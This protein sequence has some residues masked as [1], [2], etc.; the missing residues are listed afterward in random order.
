MFFHNEM[1]HNL[2]SFFLEVYYMNLRFSINICIIIFTT[3]PPTVSYTITVLT[4]NNDNA[5]TDAKVFIILFGGNDG[6]KSSGKIWLQG[7]GD[8]FGQGQT[9]V[10]NILVTQKLSPLSKIKIGHDNSEENAGWFLD[11]VRNKL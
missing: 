3:V 4:G 10:F 9:D 1:K 7:E 11:R 6:N 2:K 5:A 8:K